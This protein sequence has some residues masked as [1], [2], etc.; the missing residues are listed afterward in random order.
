MFAL[1]APR[2]RGERNHFGN[3]FSH[4]FRR[5]TSTWAER[6]DAIRDL[7][8]VLERIRPKA[9][10][11]LFRKDERDLFN[12]LN[13]FQIRHFDAD[14]KSDYDRRIFLTWAFYECLAAIH[15]CERLSARPMP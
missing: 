13:S 15:A 8:D 2:T 4:G 10:E 5:G 12:L 11:H 3:H 7:G 9:K 1:R 6:E 14:Q